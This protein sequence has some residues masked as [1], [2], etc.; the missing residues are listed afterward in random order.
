MN[1][2]ICSKCRVAEPH[3]H[4]RKFYE[5]EWLGASCWTLSARVNAQSDSK[6]EFADKKRQNNPHVN[7]LW[8]APIYN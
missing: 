1:Y 8:E 2:A 4:L 3:K 5:K 6:R 7:A